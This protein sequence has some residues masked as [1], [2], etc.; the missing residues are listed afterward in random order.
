MKQYIKWLTG[1]L[2]VAGGLAMVNPVHAQSVVN[3][4]TI[5]PS[6]LTVSPNALYPNWN[7]ATFTSQPTGLEVNSHGYG[8]GYYVV[9]VGQV[10]TL[11]TNDTM[12]TLTLTV[13]DFGAVP[14]LTTSGIWIGLPFILNDNSGAQ[15]LPT[16]GVDAYSGPG[17]GGNPEGTTWSTNVVDGVSNLVC[18]E[19]IDLTPAEVASIQ[20][21]KD[22]IY[23]FN[24]ECD[25][26]SDLADFYDITFNSLVLSAPAPTG[27][28][29]IAA[30]VS[31]TTLTLSWDS[32]TYPGYVLQSAMNSAGITA[33]ASWSNVSGGNTSPVTVT[34]DP[35]QPAV[36]FRL[37][38]P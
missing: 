33:S 36:F 23:A 31:G 29:T 24:L 28:P 9:P 1:A 37:S 3:F 27:L 30:S 15:T 34:I 26:S 6:T 38:N 32:T 35:T 25:P 7:T 22:A 10:Q 13:N 14:A 2:V 11:A 8:S 12:A 4:S 19:T 21:G 18:T 17:N 20:A 16:N 5:D